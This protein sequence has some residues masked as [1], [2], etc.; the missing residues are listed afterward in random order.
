MV[1]YK[2]HEKL[3]TGRDNTV[4]QNKTL[5]T[6][7]IV[8]YG[9]AEEVAQAA[10]SVAEHTQGVDL[11]LMILDNASPDGAGNQ[12][13]KMQFPKNVQ[14]KCSQTNLGFGKGHNFIFQ[15]LNQNQK[16]KYHAVINPDIT[17]DTDAIT[18]ICRWM[19]NHPD[20]TMVT[21]RLM[22]PDG[23]EQQ[24]AKRYPSLMALA[25]RQLP[26]PFLKGVEKHY[27]ML[28][29]DLT[30]PTDVQFC[31]GCFFVMRSDIYQKMGGFDPRYFVYVEDA[32][33]TR[34]ALQYGRA[35]YLPQVSVYH[36]WHRD[37]NKKLKNFTMQL[38]SM[39]KYWHKWGFKF[40]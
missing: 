40:I 11:H 6:A 21:P 23:T 1:Q 29:E 32:D 18:E 35:I 25:A 22:F 30:K 28:D 9:G 10:I 8:A 34:Q 2:R 20:V 14:L 36:A 37:A 39:F 5:V 24:T 17:L 33:I 38:G 19:D 4:E 7:G 31:S 13:Q 15:F 12:L 16:S 27:L 3:C 26:L